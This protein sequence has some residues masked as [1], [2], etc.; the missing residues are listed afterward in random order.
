MKNIFITT[1][2]CFAQLMFGEL[3]PAEI[4]ADH[5]VLQQEK[6]IPV[7]G[8]ADKGEKITVKLGKKLKTVKTSKDGK[9]ME[10]R[11]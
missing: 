6:E 4:F 11:P 9:W 8:T 3:K 5:M 1:L 7:W 2:I 10:M